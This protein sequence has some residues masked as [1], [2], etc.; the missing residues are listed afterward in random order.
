MSKLKRFH[1]TSGF[2]QTS[3]PIKLPLRPNLLTGEDVPIVIC[4]C[5]YIYTHNTQAYTDPIPLLPKK[6]HV[7][8]MLDHHIEIKKLNFFLKEVDQEVGCLKMM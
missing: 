1:F 8:S 6:G 3:K 5:I 4:N 2:P 7:Q